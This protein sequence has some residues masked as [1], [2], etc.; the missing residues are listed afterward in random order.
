MNDYTTLLIATGRTEDRLR[1]AARAR[2]ATM[3]AGGAR[4]RGSVLQRLV[5]R[6]AS[7]G[8]A[9]VRPVAPLSTEA[10]PC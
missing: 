5:R 6:A 10:R 2:L 3:A 4:D 1:E 9:K 8:T 7:R